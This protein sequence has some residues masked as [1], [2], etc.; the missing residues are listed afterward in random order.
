MCNLITLPTTRGYY[1]RGLLC[2]HHVWSSI[3]PKRQ[4]K[5]SKTKKNSPVV[6]VQS[7]I[8]HQTSFDC[9][10]FF[11]CVLSCQLSREDVPLWLIYKA[12]CVFLSW[13]SSLKPYYQCSFPPTVLLLNSAKVPESSCTQHWYLKRKFPPDLRKINWKC[14]TSLP[15][16]YKLHTDV[17]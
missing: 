16:F 2:L 5:T 10:I 13:S 6:F 11:V 7:L 14:H 4:K 17:E 3:F 8:T 12:V 1:P 15:L 9:S